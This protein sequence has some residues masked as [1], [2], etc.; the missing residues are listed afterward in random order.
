MTGYFSDSSTDC[1][2]KNSMAHRAS[3]FDQNKGNLIFTAQRF[4]LSPLQ[5][6]TPYS[7]SVDFLDLV[8]NWSFLLRK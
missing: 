3:R 2:A 8:K 6:G 7:Q 5:L 1:R 4:A